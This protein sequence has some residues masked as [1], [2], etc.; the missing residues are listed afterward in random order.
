MAPAPDL[1]F[2]KLYR[3]DELTDALRLLAE[4]RPDLMTLA[5]AGQSHEGRDIWLA[6]VTNTA[7]G[8]ADEKPALFVEANIHATEVTGSTA[9]LH[10]LHTLVSRY[11]EDEKVTRALDTRAFY[12]IPR[13]NPDGVER[14]LADKPQFIR[15][16]VRPYPR[17]D[18]Q[19]G[20][21]EEDVDGDG[22]ILTMR[23]EDPNG[24]WKVY[25]DDPRLLIARE[26]DEVGTGPYYRLLPEGSIRN[27]DGVIV[28]LAPRVEGLDL[29]RNFPA[30]WRTEGEQHGAGP[31]P[32][33]EPE[34]RAVV[35]AVIERPNVCGY[36]AY[37]TFSGVHLRPYS[38]HAD[39]HF[40]TVDL[41]V[42]KEI[43][44]R[45]TAITGYKAVSV[46]HDFQY[47]PKNAMTG[48]SDDWAYD[49]LGVF[50][51]TTEFWGPQQQAGIEDHH[52]I[53]WWDDHPLEHDLK[54]LAWTDEKLGGTAY[55]DWYPFDHPQLGRV[56]LGGWDFFR[57]WSNPPPEFMEA[58]I[59]PHA[60]FA[61][62]HL[63]ISPRLELHSTDVEHLGDGVWRVRLVVQNSG[64][65]PTNVTQKAVERKVVRPIEAEITLPDGASLVGVEGKL[66]LGQLTGR[67]LKANVLGAGNDP[68]DDRAK[69][70]W[71]VRAPAGT[72][73]EVEARHQRAGVVRAS[74]EL[75]QA[76]GM[77]PPA[78]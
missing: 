33:S 71:V 18:K 75:A 8:P 67:A 12:V 52:F 11:G 34:I 19:D 37:H 38:A 1:R 28:R 61:V 43:G 50:S 51:W 25:A 64:W 39:E 3:Y 78:T 65:L 41:R 59:R 46:F 4:A 36:I 69:A 35:Q 53:E 42:Y 44:K 62:F 15:S 2:D 60:D 40:P 29:N 6:T 48:A 17:T 7:T 32:T 23:I 72:T 22:R 27:Y 20:L 66:E 24:T 55:V 73:V 10:L 63:L 74:I 30:E 49:H 45:A 26:P 70:E 56:E 13:L 16:S 31:F 58:E 14:A 54:L 9:A 68:T 76:A 5:A 57:S 77:R 47:D 21:F